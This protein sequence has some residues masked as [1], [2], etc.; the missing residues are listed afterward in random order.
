MGTCIHDLDLMAVSMVLIFLF[1]WLM[2]WGGLE[3]QPL[4]FL[5]PF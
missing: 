4:C 5:F 3:F 1:T 2:V